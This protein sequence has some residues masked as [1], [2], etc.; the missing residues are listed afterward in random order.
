VAHFLVS[1]GKKWATF[2]VPRLA[3]SGIFERGDNSLH[4]G[5]IGVL[6]GRPVVL[7]GAI[8]VFWVSV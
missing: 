1:H 5:V 4:F 6:F 2:F 3:L 7:V 8:E